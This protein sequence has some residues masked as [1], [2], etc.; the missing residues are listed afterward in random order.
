MSCRRVGC[1]LARTLWRR[2]PHPI[3]VHYWDKYDPVE[4]ADEL[5]GFITSQNQQDRDKRMGLQPVREALQPSWSD[6]RLF[7]GL[8]VV[9]HGLLSAPARFA[10]D[11]GAL[12]AFGGARHGLKELMIALLA[13]LFHGPRRFLDWMEAVHD[14]QIEANAG[15]CRHCDAAVRPEEGECDPCRERY[16]R[17]I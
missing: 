11:P 13:T 16:D 8:L 10:Q 15:K 14:R 7:V 4:S 9:H 1:A 6:A 5:R 2:D 17:Y 12:R 3:L